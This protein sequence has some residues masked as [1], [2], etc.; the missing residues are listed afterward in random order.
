MKINVKEQLYKFTNKWYGYIPNEVDLCS[1]TL[2]T[3]FAVLKFGGLVALVLQPAAFGPLGYLLDNSGGLPNNGLLCIYYLLCI[4]FLIF[5]TI[6]IIS[7]LVF[8]SVLTCL[9]V[10]EYL[11]GKLNDIKCGRTIKFK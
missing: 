6:L 7:V 3:I 10:V 8:K 1:F 11:R 4:F 5:Y 9:T 2:K